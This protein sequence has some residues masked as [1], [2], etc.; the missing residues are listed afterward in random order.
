[1]AE[2]FSQLSK[3]W[4]SKLELPNYKFNE[5]S[6]KTVPAIRQ[7]GKSTYRKKAEKIMT[8]SEM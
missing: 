1:M 7:R 3:E 2:K 5:F 4:V 6:L 8:S